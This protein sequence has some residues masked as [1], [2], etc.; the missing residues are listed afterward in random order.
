MKPVTKCLHYS[1]CNRHWLEGAVGRKIDIIEPQRDQVE[2][3]RIWA[4]PNSIRAWLRDSIK[5][6]RLTRWDAK[7]GA[8]KTGN[9]RETGT[10]DLQGLSQRLRV[11]HDSSMPIKCHVL[12]G[13]IN[14]HPPHSP[15]SPHLSSHQLR[16]ISLNLTLNPISTQLLPDAI[17]V[18]RFRIA[19]FLVPMTRKSFLVPIGLLGELF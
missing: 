7:R 4:S 8:P 6:S 18:V 15:H 13:G 2:D 12:S 10:G 11:T 3:A 16:L 17:L 14:N 5:V 1:K 19:P 9:N